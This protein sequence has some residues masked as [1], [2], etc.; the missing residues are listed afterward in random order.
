MKPTLFLLILLLLPMAGT[1]IASGKDQCSIQELSWM[2]GA[3][4]GEHE[5]IKMEEVW[6]SPQGGTMLGLHR[7]LFPSGKVF[8]EFMRIVET[9]EGVSFLASPAGRQA[10]KFAMLECSDKRVVFDNPTHDY[11]QKV[12]YWLDVQGY[13][14]ARIAGWDK[15]QAKKAEWVW[16]PSDL[17]VD[18]R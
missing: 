5:G 3:W 17:A 4:K 11:P 10:T 6:T 18:E 7:D 13:L 12:G 8:F 15:G 9:P 2:T 1:P 16:L 14:H